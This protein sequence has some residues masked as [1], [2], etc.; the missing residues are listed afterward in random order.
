MP[1][2]SSRPRVTT[3]AEQGEKCKDE[4]DDKVLNVAVSNP[5]PTSPLSGGR[6]N[7]LKK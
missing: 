3:P 7:A 5:H 6:A 4:F 2:R 1:R